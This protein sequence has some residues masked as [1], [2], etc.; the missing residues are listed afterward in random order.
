MAPALLAPQS[1]LL[2]QHGLIGC[3][4]GY[5]ESHREEWDP[6]V[7]EAAAVSAVAVELSAM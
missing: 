3:S 1:P 2:R 7:V 6:L 4:T 5:M